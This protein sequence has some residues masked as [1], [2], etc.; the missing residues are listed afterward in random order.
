MQLSFHWINCARALASIVPRA[1]RNMEDVCNFNKYGYCKFKD[2][3]LK[4]HENNAWQLLHC[5]K[6]QCRLFHPKICKYYAINDYYKF[7]EECR[8]LHKDKEATRMADLE[9]RITQLNSDLNSMKNSLS[10]SK[11][12]I[13]ILQNTIQ[14]K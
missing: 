1:R 6:M 14:I 10:E 2:K 8:Y 9:M 7:W 13:E 12:L 3:S 5:G 11:G 4:P